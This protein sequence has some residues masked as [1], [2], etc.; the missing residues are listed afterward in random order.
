MKQHAKGKRR[1]KPFTEEYQMAITVGAF[2][3]LVALGFAA[4]GIYDSRHPSSAQSPPAAKGKV[5]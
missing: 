1:R 4:V 2:L 3:A 5:R